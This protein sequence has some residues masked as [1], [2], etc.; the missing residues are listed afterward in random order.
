MLKRV[1]STVFLLVFIASVV[2]RTIER[3]QAWAEQHGL[4]LKQISQNQ[5][6]VGISKG[7]KS[8]G[9]QGQTKL[10]EDG[11]ALDISFARSLHAPPSHDALAHVLTGFLGDPN[12]QIFSSRAP[13]YFA[14]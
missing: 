2:G 1:A 14:A 9:R 5:A 6:G 4:G 11:W 7:H 3:T 13:P 12:R 10:V 8:V